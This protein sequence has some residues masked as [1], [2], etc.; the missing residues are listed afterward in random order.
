MAFQ[1]ELPALLAS[2]PVVEEVRQWF[3]PKPVSASPTFRVE[4]YR[5]LV[6]VPEDFSCVLRSIKTDDGSDIVYAVT[7]RDGQFKPGHNY[8]LTHPGR[9]FVIRNGK[10]RDIVLEIPPLPSGQYAMAA[11][12]KN[13]QKDVAALAVTYFTI[14]E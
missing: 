6:G 1:V 7:A 14:A 8:S 12:I 5:P 4:V 2:F 13:R 9:N 3:I 10:T 11:S